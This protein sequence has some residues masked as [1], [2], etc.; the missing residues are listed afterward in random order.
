VVWAPDRPAALSR[1]HR[2]LSEFELEGV[3]TTRELAMDILKSE[4]FTSGVYTT[5]FLSEAVA[6]LP[7]LAET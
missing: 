4:P 3:A 5:N 6:H 7:V 1:A 2:A